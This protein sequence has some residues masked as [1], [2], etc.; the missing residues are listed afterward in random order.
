MMLRRKSVI[1]MS[2]EFKNEYIQ[3]KLA[4]SFMDGP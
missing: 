1:D 3:E 2:E 4:K